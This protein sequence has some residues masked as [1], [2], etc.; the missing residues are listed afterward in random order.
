ME[1]IRGHWAGVENRIHG[2]KDACL[3]EDKT[4]NQN[5]KIVGALVL[6]RNALLMIYT[7]EQQSDGSLP[8]FTESMAAN[9]S[10]ALTATKRRL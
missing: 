8:A 2:G 3:F 6:L 1:W 7:A 4:R 10:L 5:P 9:S